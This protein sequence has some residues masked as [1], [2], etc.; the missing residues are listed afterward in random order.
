MAP[1][2]SLTFDTPMRKTTVLASLLLSASCLAG[3]RFEI[4]G[5]AVDPQLASR[6]HSSV[7]DSFSSRYTAM[8]KE[9]DG[10]PTPLVIAPGDHA[11]VLT[12]VRIDGPSL[13]RK[14]WK[15]RKFRGVYRLS[16]TTKPGKLYA[17]VFGGSDQASIASTMCLV[18]VDQGRGG[19]IDMKNLKA[20]RAARVTRDFVSCSA[21]DLP[22]ESDFSECPNGADLFNC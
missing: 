11:I 4:G 14:A 15:P 2:L 19:I 22:P 13:A 5:K 16:V 12:Y 7:A 1:G 18:E 21:P 20:I 6:L 8:I 3:P 17:P 9:V 10:Q